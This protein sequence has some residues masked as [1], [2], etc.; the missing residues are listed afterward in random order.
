[1]FTK[2]LKRFRSLPKET[3]AM[4]YLYWIYEFAEL[5][6]QIFMAAFVFLNTG[7]IPALMAYA[8]VYFTGIAVGFSGWGYL[9][10][11]WKVSMRLK[12]LRYFFIY[13]LS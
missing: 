11:R 6:V 5:I 10:S 13:T 1:M 7:S 12:Y 4:V 9:V 3:Q 2:T 8:A